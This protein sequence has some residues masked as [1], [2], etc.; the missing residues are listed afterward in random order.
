MWYNIFI[1]NFE[2]ATFMKKI[3]SLAVR[4]GLAVL[5]IVISIKAFGI[6]FDSYFWA[7][8]S[9]YGDDLFL[10]VGITLMLAF[11]GGLTGMMNLFPVICIIFWR[12]A[13]PEDVRKDLEEVFDFIW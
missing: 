8:F 1:K 5:C 11:F 3:L 6:G 12:G 4:T 13:P 2:E 7:Q 10:V 9:I